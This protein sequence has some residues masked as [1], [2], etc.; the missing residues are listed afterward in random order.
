[1]GR[2]DY[3]RCDVWGIYRKDAGDYQR[4]TG[5]CK[6]GG[7]A[8]YYDGWSDVVMGGTY[9]DRGMCGDYPGGKQM[10]AAVY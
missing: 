8:V 3:C 7:Y 9:G 6:R 5:F 2:N 4:G 10:D 1:M